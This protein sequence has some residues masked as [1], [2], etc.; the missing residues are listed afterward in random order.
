MPFRGRGRGQ[1]RRVVGPIGGLRHGASAWSGTL[2]S[3]SPRHF[4]FALPH[5][6]KCRLS[7]INCSLRERQ[8]FPNLQANPLVVSISSKATRA[9]NPR[10]DI[11]NPLKA[12]NNLPRAT[13]NLPRATNSRLRATRHRTLVSTLAASTRRSTRRRTSTSSLLRPSNGARLLSI[14]RNNGVHRL[15]NNNRPLR[16]PS[17][18]VASLTHHSLAH[19]RQSPKIVPNLPSHR[20]RRTFL[21]RKPRRCT[22]SPRSPSRH[23]CRRTF[24]MRLATMA[25]VTRKS[26]CTQMTQPT[27]FIT[28]IA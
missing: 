22:G 28:T 14:N 27:R 15:R 13:N 4:S 20:R 6:L 16:H 19:R 9:S 12:T 3:S 26:R 24:D 8:S 18:R 11:N 2:N 7:L 17:H 21:P 25:G 1:A 23:P 10:Q 5:H